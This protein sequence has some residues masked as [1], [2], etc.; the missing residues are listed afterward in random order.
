MS[1][2]NPSRTELSAFGEFNLIKHLTQNVKLHNT[3][4]I[5]GIGDD[6]AVIQSKKS[7][8]VI[9]TDLLTEKVHFDLSYCPMKHLGYKSISVNL[10]DIYAMNAEPKQVLVSIAVS[11]R[12]S[13]EALEELYEGMLLACNLY[14]V[15]LVG[16]DTTSSQSGLTINIT[17]IGECEENKLVKRSTANENDLVCVSGDLGGA[18]LGLQILEREKL[19]FKSDP[20][21]QPN[22]EGYDY[23]IERQLKPEPRRDVIEALQNI[24]VVPTAMI[25][26]SDGLASEI[27]FGLENL[28]SETYRSGNS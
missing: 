2:E 27:F 13:V 18:Y 3:S 4:S 24:E 28:R 25:D 6:C 11:N 1:A 23:I 12:F 15:D 14:K 17:A 20:N 21:I 7:H 5:I 22:L 26:I 9:T 8:Q 16:G 10:S 19:V